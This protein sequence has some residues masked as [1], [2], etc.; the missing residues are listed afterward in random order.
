MEMLLHSIN[1]PLP[2]DMNNFFK[3]HKEEQQE[4]REMISEAEIDA[5]LGGQP[6]PETAE[7]DSKDIPEHIEQAHQNV[8]KLI[9]SAKQQILQVMNTTDTEG[10]K[11]L[12]VIQ[13]MEGNV[14]DSAHDYNLIA[15]QRLLGDYYTFL[16]EC[17]AKLKQLDDLSKR[18]TDLYNRRVKLGC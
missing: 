2:S 16:N 11:L 1:S 5:L 3:G 4:L 8:Q 6:A 10:Y 7:E 13:V 18:E 12:H 17:Y 15:A 9:K 14:V